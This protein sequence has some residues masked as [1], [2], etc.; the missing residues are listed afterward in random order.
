MAFC[1][2]WELSKSVQNVQSV[3]PL[4]FYIMK[5]K[6]IDII[7]FFKGNLTKDHYARVLNGDIVIQRRPKRTKPATEAQIKAR[8]EFSEKYAGKH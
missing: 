3:S 5:A 8:K 1:T 4:N 2:F 7:K 6:A